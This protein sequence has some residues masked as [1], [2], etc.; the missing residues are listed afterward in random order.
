VNEIKFTSSG[1]V[2]SRQ[3]RASFHSLLDDS[4]EIYDVYEHGMLIPS[5]ANKH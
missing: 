5:A 4:G 1:L 3:S 2:G